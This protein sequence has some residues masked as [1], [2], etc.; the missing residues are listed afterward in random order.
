MNTIVQHSDY[1]YIEGMLKNNT[2]T[3]KKIYKDHFPGILKLISNNN[4]TEDDARD[5]FQNALLVIYDNAQQPDFHLKSTFFSYI[6]S[7]AR[8][9]WLRQL[10]KKHRKHITISGHE[11][12]LVDESVEGLQVDQEKRQLFEEIFERLAEDCRNVLKLFFDGKSLKAIGEELG[13]S[14]SY[15]KL[16]KYNCK[17][18]F[19]KWIREDVRYQELVN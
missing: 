11:G 16:K 9:I 7:V 15:T 17:E 2:P 18:Q 4:G 1:Q 8:F 5:V 10:K 13:Y 19:Y 12:L 6:Y 3:I 14:A